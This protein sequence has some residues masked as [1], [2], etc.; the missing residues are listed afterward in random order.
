VIGEVQVYAVERLRNAPA[1]PAYAPALAGAGSG[2]AYER[3][4]TVDTGI[5]EID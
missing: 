3:P 2:D 4:R 1:R 5:I